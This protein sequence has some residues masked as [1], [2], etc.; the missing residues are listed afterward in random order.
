M[1]RSEVCIWRPVGR[2]SYPPGHGRVYPGLA[3]WRGGTRITYLEK[4]LRIR[5]AGV[6][7]KNSMGLRKI[8]KAILSW[9]FR[10]AWFAGVTL[11]LCTSNGGERGH[12]SES[13]SMLDGKRGQGTH[14]NRAEDP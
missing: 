12:Q 5:P 11:A 10:E 2:V 9:S 4:R 14:L 8:A 13:T 7:S 6:V 1:D 3:V